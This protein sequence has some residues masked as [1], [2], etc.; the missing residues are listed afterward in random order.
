[1]VDVFDRVRVAS[2]GRLDIKC[3][4]VGEIVPYGD[5]LLALKDGVIDM[6]WSGMQGAHTIAGTVAYIIAPCGLPGSPGPIGLLA[7]YYAGDGEEMY[8]ELVKDY[9]ISIGCITGQAELFCHSNV[10]LE[11]AEDFRGIKFRTY[12]MWGE[13][14]EEEFGA[15][16]VTLSGGEIYEAV[17]RGLIDAFEYTV[18]SMNW[19]AGFHEVTKYVGVPG[20]HSPGWVSYQVVNRDSWSAL[21]PALQQIL[22]DEIA[23]YTTRNFLVDWFAD[24]EAME[25]YKEY[26]TEI[27]TLSLEF[28]E[29]IARL[30]K[31]YCEKY[32]DE[33]PLFKKVYENQKEFFKTFRG[34][35]EVVQP[36]YCLF[37]Y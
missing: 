8:N 2:E 6:C 14:L 30:G 21:P 15:S 36:K 11:S 32:A 1:M 31:K 33:D 34:V 26:G 27:V 25:K 18:P 13:I 37:D 7:W 23:A 22:K 35:K 3:S 17:A 16:V 10:K 4:P 9:G 12:G 24:G 29:E 5:E 19:P 20:I 28:Q